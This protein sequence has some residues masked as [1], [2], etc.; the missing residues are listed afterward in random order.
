MC[1]HSN[2]NANTQYSDTLCSP[3]IGK[4]RA[5]VQDPIV[6]FTVYWHPPQTEQSNRNNNR[7]THGTTKKNAFCHRKCAYL[8]MKDSMKIPQWTNVE[9]LQDAP[10]AL[11]KNF[12]YFKASLQ[13][14]AGNIMF[15]R[16]LFHFCEHSISATTSWGDFLQI[17]YKH[18]FGLGLE[19]IQYLGHDSVSVTF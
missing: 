17:W 18:S 8:E 11:L 5:G 4:L 16:C 19:P 13:A 9:Y 3:G 1:T 15:S 10:L 14:T 7:K 6:R 12:E 2:G